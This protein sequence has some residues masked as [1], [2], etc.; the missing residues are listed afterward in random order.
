MKVVLKGNCA[1][2]HLLPVQL[3]FAESQMVCLAWDL[4]LVEKF[5]VN[6][7]FDKQTSFSEF[8]KMC[9]TSAQ[10]ILSRQNN[11]LCRD[12]RNVG[13]IS[14]VVRSTLKSEDVVENLFYCQH[15]RFLRSWHNCQLKL[16]ATF[17][18]RV[19][20]RNFSNF[21]FR[22][23]YRSKSTRYRIKFTSNANSRGIPTISNLL[24]FLLS[25][26]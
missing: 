7:T 14:L 9:S 18:L 26:L 19:R 8:S 5:E 4:V 16:R 12:Q 22:T 25:I 13:F 2:F 17:K 1:L 20:L 3:S 21:I 11:L 15:P 24:W 23:R 6:N 10:T